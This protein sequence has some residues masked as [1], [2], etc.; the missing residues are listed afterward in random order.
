MRDKAHG[1]ASH[2]FRAD[3]SPIP[4]PAPWLT[5]PLGFGATGMVMRRRARTAGISMVWAERTTGK[6]PAP[7]RGPDPAG[8]T[9]DQRG[10]IAR[11]AAGT[12]LN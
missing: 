7:A 9:T 6:G 3:D 2:A 1:Y 12:H 5:M 10:V 4:E 11:S 8:R